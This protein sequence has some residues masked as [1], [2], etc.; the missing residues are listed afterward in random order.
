MLPRESPLSI[1]HHPSLQSFLF[2]SAR[3]LCAGYWTLSLTLTASKGEA[4]LSNQL[5]LIS[6]DENH[7]LVYTWRLL[8]GRR[9]PWEKQKALGCWAVMPHAVGEL[10]TY[11]LPLQHVF[12]KPLPA[13]QSF[14]SWEAHGEK[15]KTRPAPQELKFGQLQVC[16][17]LKLTYSVHWY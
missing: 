11:R 1:T 5:I 4:T 10:L 9:Q 2:C 6:S 17:M 13:P 14:S 12:T 3:I 8:G 7:P 15:Q 16:L